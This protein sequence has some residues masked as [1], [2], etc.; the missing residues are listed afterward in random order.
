MKIEKHSRQTMP[1]QWAKKV[2]V[3]SFAALSLGFAPS[4]TAAPSDAAVAAAPDE[5]RKHITGVVQD[6]NGPI[7]G[8][9]VVQRGTTVGTVT[10]L[11]GRFDLNVPVGSTIDVSFVGYETTSFRVGSASSYRVNLEEDSQILEE[12]V[13]VGYGTMKKS[14]LTGSVSSVSSEDLNRVP[15][16]DPAQALQGRAAGVVVTASSGSP[17]ASTSIRIRGIGTMNDASPLYVVDGFP[18]GDIHHL[19]PS[20]IESIEILKDASA[21][22]IYGSR[23]ANG[24]VVITTKKGNAG[25]AKVNF[26]AYYGFEK[27]PETPDMMN[28]S[29][30]VEVRK[31]AFAAS[32]DSFYTSGDETGKV[33]TNWWDEVSRTGQYQNYN[34]TVSGGSEKVQSVM[35]ANYFKREGIIKSTAFDRI[36]VSNKTTAEV[37]KWLKLTSSLSYSVA[38]IDGGMGTGNIMMTSLIAPPNV[39]VW[40]ETTD[41]YSGL[42]DV[43]LAN[44][45]GRI[46]R[47]NSE[48]NRKF[49]VGNFSADIKLYKDLVFTSRFGVKHRNAGYVGYTPIYY[50]TSSISSAKTTI[51]RSKTNSTDWTW[52]NQ[53]TY[54]HKWAKKH[55]FTAMVATSARDYEYEYMSGTKDN[56]SGDA[57]RYWY[58]NS[59]TDN[60]QVSGNGSSLSMFS[61]LGRINYNYGDRYLLTVSMRAD[62]SSR[63][64]EDNRWGYFPSAAAG[65]RLSEESFFERAKE[66]VNNAKIRLGYGE[67]GNEN[68]SSYY[69]YI[70]P[71]AVGR[72]YTVGADQA[73]VNGAVPNAIGNKDAKWETSTQF[74]VGVDL[75]F[76]NNRLNV[77]ADY[78]VR[79]TEDILMNQSIPNL[80]GFSTMVRNVGGMKNTGLELT[81]SWKDSKGDFSYDV[82]ANIAFVKNEVTNLGT[83]DLL[84]AYGF[85]YDYDLINLQGGLGQFIRSE[86]GEPYGQYYGRVTDGIFQ[87]QAEIDSYGIQPDA[88]PGDF[89]FKDLNGDGKIDDNDREYIGS[90]I[91]T[92]TYGISF[93]AAYKGWD[94]NLLFSGVFG[95]EIFNASKYYLYRSDGSFNCTKEYYD[96]YWKAD[97][98][99]NE[100]PALTHDA[101][102]NS[103]NFC[104]SDYYIESGSYLRLKNIQVGYTFK[105]KI[106][107]RDTSI[108]VYLASSN[109]LTFTGYSGF[110]PEIGAN[111]GVDCGQYPHARSFQIGT[112]INF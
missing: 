79:K 56:V 67:I 3:L 16:S 1:C 10:D 34:V 98:N 71:I 102:R 43:R 9:S 11:D 17:D 75:G 8:A 74:N 110:D 72:Y 19:A 27:I 84:Y 68:I 88:Q 87:T 73:R 32:G 6:V 92:A 108:R 77:T 35:S 51:S 61:Y 106:G 65:W 37:T 96:N 53:L 42:L 36:N 91:P 41:Y 48:S 33:N 86:V 83:S 14:D 31:A 20:D 26:N 39:S 69:P 50:E 55:D 28:A 111:Y 22:A 54:H 59:A 66:V 89:K 4:L 52:E 24:V 62:G 60:P 82:N 23:G 49:F 18:M 107:G 80:S 112:S 45:A 12:M 99:T 81:A 7:V 93:N 38:N 85:D 97:R 76:L 13:V 70:T 47:N 90:S 103:R 40:N 21:C 46:Y 30:Y 64:S 104:A 25:N 105:P 5:A 29:Q 95:N 2:F 63:F 44:P 109:L 78:Y 100:I 94:I 101:T 15:V 58:F 57:E